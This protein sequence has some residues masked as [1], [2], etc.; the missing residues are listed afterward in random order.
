MV[1]ISNTKS[2]RKDEFNRFISFL[3]TIVSNTIKIKDN[4]NSI[5]KNY[6]GE[7]TYFSTGKK[8]LSI[9]NSINSIYFNFPDIQ[10]LYL[11]EINLYNEIPDYRDTYS[12]LFDDS[13]ILEDIRVKKLNYEKITLPV[14]PFLNRTQSLI[15]KYKN[16]SDKNKTILLNIETLQ[17]K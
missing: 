4:I 9:S 1:S 7:G 13:P 11:S 12:I 14:R 8:M 15:F 16:N 10:G 17:A 6:W 2:I 3:T 5:R